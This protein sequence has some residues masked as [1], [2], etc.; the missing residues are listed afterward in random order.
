MTA[1]RGVGLTPM[2]TRRDVIVRAAVLAD[3]LGYEIFALPEGWGLDPALGQREDL[4]AQLVGEHGGADDDIAPGLHRREPHAAAGGHD[5][6]SAAC[7]G[8]GRGTVS[9]TALAVASTLPPGPSS[10]DP[11]SSLRPSHPAGQAITRH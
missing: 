4:I 3:E 8:T 2:E 5:C 1:R 10:A 9:H 11:A 6:P 7:A